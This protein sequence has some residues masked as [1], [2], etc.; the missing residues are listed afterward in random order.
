[1]ATRRLDAQDLEDLSRGAWILGTGGGG[2]PYQALLELKQ[3]HAAGHV[4]ELMESIVVASESGRHVE[5]R[6]TCE[7]PAPLP[8]GL[9]DDTF[10]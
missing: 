7:R 9:P 1:M 6:T 4:L 2:D 3:L 8:P 5:P 10:G